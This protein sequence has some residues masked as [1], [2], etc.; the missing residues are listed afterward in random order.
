MKKKILFFVPLP[1]PI[2]GAALRN[3][4]LVESAVLNR[5]FD[6]YVIPFNF[7]EEV[8]DIGKFSSRKIYKSL[9]RAFS[10]IRVV[11]SFRPDLV[12]FNLSLYGF[13]LYR[14]ILFVMIFKTLRC[15][16]LFHLRTQGV[17]KQVSESGIKRFIF[18]TIFHNSKVICLSDFLSKDIED[19]YPL[20]PI[21]VNNGI[22]DVTTKFDVNIKTPSS[23]V[24][25][26]YLGH[27]WAFKGIEDLLQALYLLKL[28]GLE[29]HATIAG[30]EG[31]ITY[32][33][34]REKIMRLGLENSVDVPGSQEGDDKYQ[35]YLSADIFVLPTHFEAFPG[36]ILEAMQFSLPVVS[37]FE[38]A[39]PEIVDNGVT[40]FLVRKQ[41]AQDLSLH[42]KKLIQDSLLRKTM[43]RNARTRFVRYYNLELFEQNMKSAF[44]SALQSFDRV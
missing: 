40:G 43:G 12:Y 9:T 29:F 26:M 14:D 21:I 7:A 32:D 27:L 4:S 44:T 36:V 3:K 35:L 28:D 30:P 1:P 33:S 11:L 24:N 41:D 13:A 31:D 25:I 5:E 6:I 16:L 19:I 8:K 2:T 38:G 15:R 20:K 18:K 22:E 23:K 17:K 39:I 42:L 37:T 10:I 34:L